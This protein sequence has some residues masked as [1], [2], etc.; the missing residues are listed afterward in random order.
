MISAE[1]IERPKMGF[2]VPINFW[3][4]GPLQDWDEALLDEKRLKDYMKV[5]TIIPWQVKILS[6]LILSRI[7]SNYRL[8]QRIGLFKHGQMEQPA[9]AFNIF[10]MH[11]ERGEY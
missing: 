5:K 4:R 2:G 8:W 11:Y 7:S 3:L 1:L 10:K 9:Y 6:K